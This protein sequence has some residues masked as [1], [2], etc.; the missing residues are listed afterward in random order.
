MEISGFSHLFPRWGQEQAG[1][2]LQR[3]SLG[4][5]TLCPWLGKVD[6]D[7]QDLPQ[8]PEA[9]RVPSPAAGDA[10]SS[11]QAHTPRQAWSS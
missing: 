6:N 1:Q 4:A 8:A 2:A 9:L 5:V 11:G 3:V 10:V 7:Q